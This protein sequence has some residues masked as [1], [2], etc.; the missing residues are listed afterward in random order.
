MS[1]MGPDK[2]VYM[3]NQIG[4]F[5][6]AQGSEDNAIAGVAEHIKKFWNPQMRKSIYA[7]ID[8]GGEGLK[9]HVKAAIEK[10]KQAEAAH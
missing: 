1:H 4:T 6:K 8:R 5:F 2:L 7:H 3:A 9:P 10:L